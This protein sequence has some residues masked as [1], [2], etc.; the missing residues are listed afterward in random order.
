MGSICGKAVDEYLSASDGPVSMD[1]TNYVYIN[2]KTDQGVRWFTPF[3]TITVR[4]LEIDGRSDAVIMT[5]AVYKYNIRASSFTIGPLMSDLLTYRRQHN[6]VMT[7]GVDNTVWHA[8]NGCIGH[9]T[10]IDGKKNNLADYTISATRCICS[11]VVN[12]QGTVLAIDAANNVV[13]TKREKDTD[14]K[15]ILMGGVVFPRALVIDHDDSLL[16]IDMGTR[17]LL[18]YSAHIPGK[19]D[20]LASWDKKIDTI[21]V[22]TLGYESVG[23]AVA[24][25]G[26]IIITFPTNDNIYLVKDGGL[27]PLVSRVCNQIQSPRYPVFDSYNKLHMV[28]NEHHH[29]IIGLFPSSKKRLRESVLKDILCNDVLRLVDSYI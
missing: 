11:I 3:T 8:L 18:K 15:P 1:D 7:K 26:Q 25:G 16:I 28:I 23:L 17:N 14:F 27:V 10:Y 9:Y 22:K 2:S 12:T 5:L 4:D 19:V 20:C 24:Q 21:D 6:N 29:E 13:I